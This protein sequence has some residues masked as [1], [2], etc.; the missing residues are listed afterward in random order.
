MANKSIS[1]TNIKV[2]NG[3]QNSG[4]EEFCCQLFPFIIQSKITKMERINGA[5]GDGG[6]EAKCHL[7]D[8]RIIGLQ[9]KYFSK[10]TPSQ[11]SQINKS[12]ETMIKN[13]PDIVEYYVCVPLNR[14][15]A[16]IKT[17][18]ARVKSWKSKATN[19]SIVFK[20]I[21]ESELLDYLIR[22]E[23]RHIQS[24]WFDCS[25]FDYR[26]VVEQTKICINQL[27]HRYTPKLH[28]KTQSEQTLNLLMGRGNIIDDYKKLSSDILKGW[29]K[30][31]QFVA[32]KVKE[33]N[34][35]ALNEKL[36]QVQ[37]LVT[38]LSTELFEGNITLQSCQLIEVL[39]DLEEAVRQLISALSEFESTIQ[40]QKES[41]PKPLDTIKWDLERE[42]G[43]YNFRSEQ[44]EL[45]EKLKQYIKSNSS[46]F[47]LVAG[48][49]GSG[50]S[51]LMASTAEGL[52]EAG[53]ACL[54][55]IGER[56]T[57]ANDPKQQIVEQLNWQGT[58]DQLMSCLSSLADISGKP[59]YVLIDAINETPERTL[60]N[61]HLAALAMTI[62][63]FSNVKLILSCRD[64]LL[65]ANIN[66]SLENK[67]FLISH[68]G[69]DLN[70]NE[71]VLAY[72][73]GYQVKTHHQPTLNNEFKNPLFLKT[74][75][76]AYQGK[77]LPQGTLTFMNVI[78]AWEARIAENIE[79]IID[80]PSES[81]TQAMTDIIHK[82]SESDDMWISDVDAKT[83]CKQYFSND[84]KN[85]GLYY[86]LLSEGFMCEMHS[87][88][89]TVSSFITNV[90]LQYE[91]FADI[92]TVEV[93]LKDVQTKTDLLKKWQSK[94]LPNLTQTY[95]QEERH[96][97]WRA[98]PRLFALGLLLP[99]KIGVELVECP[100][101]PVIHR[102]PNEQPFMDSFDH[103]KK[104]MWNA[105]LD[106][107]NWRDFQKDAEKVKTYFLLWANTIARDDYEVYSKLFEYACIPQHPFNA[108]FL[109]KHLCSL[110]LSERDKRWS[111]VLAYE[112]IEDTSE[113][114]VGEFLHWVDNSANLLSEGQVQLTLIP[115]LWLTSS[116]NRILR[117]KATDIAI[118]ILYKH[119]TEV[120]V[121]GLCE[122]F[123]NVNDPYVKERLLA[124]LCGA[125]PACKPE[126][127]TKLGQYVRQNFW[128]KELI[129]PNIM[130]RDYAEFIIRF[131]CSQGALD[132]EAINDIENRSEKKLPEI[133]SEEQVSKFEGKDGY[134]TI[135]SSLK[136]K[137]MG[138]YGDFGR[139]VMGSAIYHFVDLPALLEMIETGNINW[140][141]ARADDK[142]AR[143]Y[144]WQR[145]IDLG[146]SPE[147]F[148]DFEKNLRYI[149]RQRSKIERISKRVLGSKR[150]KICAKLLRPNE[151]Q[152]LQT[153]KN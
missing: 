113:G 42:S 93:M 118:R 48:N 74:L 66:P 150:I 121:M 124:V 41:K 134:F 51:H 152:V 50:K 8:G 47:L 131:A 76:E 105:W 142:K 49:A 60:W 112:S 4:F 146:W 37:S 77:V 78:R 108:N 148:G 123:F 86:K 102:S 23:T 72:F 16:Q 130:M 95:H 126:V 6:V 82:M 40:E 99:E 122:S 14:S 109:H 73:N 9:A 43:L 39:N 111:V 20:W 2:H 141:E 91:R 59:A 10:L 19:S 3:S 90:R 34:V 70:F 64:D 56:F 128:S 71:A 1:F 100:L 133:W 101:R 55:L 79:R 28:Q 104:E 18:E 144:I 80:C 54:L 24:Y 7:E 36:V 81:T 136:P 87:Q 140:Y 52:I 30:T 151:K 27:H 98:Q 44:T 110:S 97:H 147:Q 106:T 35:A 83:I 153:F 115:L 13:H 129:E 85:K 45:E 139:Y 32:R 117:N 103:D 114:I 21:G 119:P 143:R 68:H 65:K 57:N 116:T 63:Q 69:F 96:L 149:G 145:V 107:L 75:C 61:A 132:C 120:C 33:T 31:F 12:V 84:T 62:S 89:S 46:L 58:F 38:S 92:R 17:W 125:L 11:W 15:P 26:W 67:H 94:I 53:N 29:Q 127:V 137:D 25:Y 5:G 22:P 138:M 135:S 88:N